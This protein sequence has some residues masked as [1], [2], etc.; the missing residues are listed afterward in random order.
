MPDWTGFDREEKFVG[1]GERDSALLIADEVFFCKHPSNI[2]WRILGWLQSDPGEMD[3]GRK[4]SM[5]R[6]G[7][8][9]FG[10]CRP[11]IEDDKHPDGCG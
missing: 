2:V 11:V 10:D 9:F 3:H 8:P 1:D 5:P 4:I 6:F 7:M